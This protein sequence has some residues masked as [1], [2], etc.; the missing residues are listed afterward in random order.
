MSN[1]KNLFGFLTKTGV[2]KLIYRRIAVTESNIQ[3]TPNP[4]NRT[5][6]YNKIN[7][8][9][10]QSG[11]GNVCPKLTSGRALGISFENK[12]RRF[13]DNMYI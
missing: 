2:D 10:R 9:Y 11:L 5:I 6:K 12:I 3:P 7:L 4:N 8:T 13:T 1:Q